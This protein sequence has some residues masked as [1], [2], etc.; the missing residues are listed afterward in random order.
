MKAPDS[1][2]PYHLTPRA[3]EALAVPSPFYI[4]VV[5]YLK[6]KQHPLY[7][8][9]LPDLRAPLGIVGLLPRVVLVNVAGVPGLADHWPVGF[10]IPEEHV[11]ER[12][13]AQQEQR[14]DARR[15]GL[16][17]RFSNGLLG[18]I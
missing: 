7:R 1:P 3:L 10:P 9:A 11:T 5:V 18:E 12:N 15:R 8:W 14:K 13:P 17:G 6:I 16:E 4:G 2:I